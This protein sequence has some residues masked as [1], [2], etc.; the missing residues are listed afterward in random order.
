L[1]PLLDHFLPI[2]ILPLPLPLPLQ[3]QGHGCKQHNPQN[4]TYW[5]NGY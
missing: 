3:V 4:Y 1:C 2:L 5:F